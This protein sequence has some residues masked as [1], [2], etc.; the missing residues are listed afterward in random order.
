MAYDALYQ[1]VAG[2]LRFH[3]GDQAGARP[4]VV[5][6]FSSADVGLLEITDPRSPVFVAMQPGNVVADGAGWKLSVMPDQTGTRR[7]F[8]ALGAFG[9]TG[10]TEFN[11]VKSTVAAAPVDPTQTR[12]RHPD[13]VVITHS[14]FRG[15]LDRWVSTG[16]PVRAARCRCTWSSAGHLRLVQ[17][18]PARPWAVKRFCNHALTAWESWALVIVGDANENAAQLG[19]DAGRPGWAT[20]WV[21]THYQCSM[22]CRTNPS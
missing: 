17:R 14:A 12:R 3:G 13:L 10:V 1:A 20:D 15:A 21:P 18:R 22:R 16:W 19:R 8:H 2:E 11:Y 9:S 6:G 4:M 7:V 5:T